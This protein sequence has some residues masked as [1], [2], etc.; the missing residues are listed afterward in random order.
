[1]CDARCVKS[2]A[3][4]QSDWPAGFGLSTL[5]N[6]AGQ[7]EPSSGMI[8]SNDAL[9]RVLKMERGCVEDQP[10]RMKSF[11]TRQIPGVLRLVED[12]TAALR[13]F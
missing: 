11:K 8:P 10:Q 6:V 13:D 7:A 9:E 12:N 4:D 3:S 5:R 1:M 2:D